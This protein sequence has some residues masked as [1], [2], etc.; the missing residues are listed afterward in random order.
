M[1][2][3]DFAVGQDGN[4][5]SLNIE[6]PEPNPA[7]VDLA[8]GDSSVVKRKPGRPKKRPRSD[9]GGI[10]EVDAKKEGIEFTN[11]GD[12]Q[13]TEEEED[14]KKSS[15]VL[16]LKSELVKRVNVQAIKMSPKNTV[17]A[18]NSP[19]KIINEAPLVIA[20]APEKEVSGVV[21]ELNFGGGENEEEDEELIPSSQSQEQVQRIEISLTGQT[22]R[23]C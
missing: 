15:N 19:V 10:L 9:L 23:T 5:I 6:Y 18:R 21:K 3:K 8:E 16:S 14:A 2:E 1:E 11:E 20:P 13:P 17:M 4:K 12:K 7:I 22:G